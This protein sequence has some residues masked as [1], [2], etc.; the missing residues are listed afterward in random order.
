MFIGVPLGV[1]NG[2]HVPLQ[3][4]APVGL[5][6]FQTLALEFK[7]P[8]NGLATTATPTPPKVPPIP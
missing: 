2:V 4:A 1:A 7:P 5:V 8:G 6:Y 3:E